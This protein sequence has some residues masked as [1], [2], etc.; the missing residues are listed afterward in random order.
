MDTAIYTGIGI[1]VVCVLI[2][3]GIGV[4]QLRKEENKGIS[5]TAQKRKK[6]NR[7]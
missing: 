2:I 7:R 3:V 6:R 5:K 1:A 4:S